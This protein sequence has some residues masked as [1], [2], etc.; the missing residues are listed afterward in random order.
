VIYS[1]FENSHRRPFYYWPP[2]PPSISDLSYVMDTQIV[3]PRPKFDLPPIAGRTRAIIQP[4]S[5]FYD[6]RKSRHL[7][8]ETA[9]SSLKRTRGPDITTL[10]E[11]P[12][13]FVCRTDTDIRYVYTYTEV[14]RMGYLCTR[15]RI[16]RVHIYVVRT[17]GVTRP[18]DG[19]CNVYRVS[20]EKTMFTKI[21]L[22][23]VC[24]R[25]FCKLLLYL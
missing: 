18:L 2:P 9:W 14:D 25:S 10:A 3:S 23:C 15:M 12:S 21:H 17:A 20:S 22:E 5:R 24:S 19:K 16:Y 8:S 7:L 13:A 6:G 11:H 4:S 1:D